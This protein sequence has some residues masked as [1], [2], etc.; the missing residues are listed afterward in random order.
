MPRS[1]KQAVLLVDGYNIIGAWSDLYDQKSEN[2]PLQFGNKQDLEIARDKLIEV[3]LNYSA[4]EDYDTRIVFDAYSQNNPAYS[5]VVTPNLSI[6]YTDFL[7]TADTYIEKFCA[8][9]RSD[10]QSSISRLIVAT[11]DRAQQLTVIGFGAEWM[12]ALQ[13]I[14][15]VE[16]SANRSRRQHRPKNRSKGRFLFNS[17]DPE[18]QARLSAL[19]YGLPPDKL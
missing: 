3:L 14:T 18:A 10:L 2:K 11:S 13:L 15:E 19:R 12:S 5:E 7:Q 8:G 6:H 1:R 16:A 17:L 4:Y 9:F